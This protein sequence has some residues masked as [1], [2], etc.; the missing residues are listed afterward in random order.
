MSEARSGPARTTKPHGDEHELFQRHND[1]LVRVVRA[2]TRADLATVEDACA[3]AWLQLLRVQP[4][5]DNVVGW[6]RV[7]AVHE[8]YRLWRK[9]R[10]EL[11]L[12][13]PPVDSSDSSRASDL[14]ALQ[15]SDEDVAA[16][17]ELHDVLR[18]IGELPARRRR[19][20]ELHLSGLTYR[21]ITEAIGEQP[22]AIDRQIK[23][24]RDRLRRDFGDQEQTP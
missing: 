11:S 2:A 9:K 13:A 4:K 8:V 14:H 15:P 16:A 18:Q 22:R 10:G 17:A 5:R 23:K 7:V 3:T 24:A 6:L 20:F 1:H 19:I 12:D 21:E